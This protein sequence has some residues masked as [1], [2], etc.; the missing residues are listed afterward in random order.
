MYL[1]IA[2]FAMEIIVN[3]LPL[4]QLKRFTIYNLR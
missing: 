3:I 4:L 1:V 2:F